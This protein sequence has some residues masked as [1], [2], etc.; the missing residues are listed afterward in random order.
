MAH[1]R[2]LEERV[3]LAA[4]IVQPPQERARAA[5]VL[6][7]LVVG[8]DGARRVAREQRV[9]RRAL[10]LVGLGEVVGEWSVDGVAGVAVQRLDGLADAPVQG[11]PGRIEQAV[12]GDLLHEPVPEA[13]L[14]RRSPA[15]LDDQVEPHQVRERRH[16]LVVRQQALEQGQPEAAPDGARH[17]DDLARAHRQAVEPRLQGALDERRH[18]D[19][20]VGELPHALAAAQSTALDQIL[21]RLL[22]EEGVAARALGQQVGE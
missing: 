16:H 13:V 17:R 9:A 5:V 11:A 12:V 4:R 6:D 15:D 1:E 20:A 10:G 2:D 7:R 19:L 21:Q 14:R 3:P 22:E 18:G 8:V